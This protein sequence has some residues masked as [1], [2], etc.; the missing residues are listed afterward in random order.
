MYTV[1][2]VCYD[3]S[4]THLVLWYVKNDVVASY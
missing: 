4:L 3:F 2:T 1:V